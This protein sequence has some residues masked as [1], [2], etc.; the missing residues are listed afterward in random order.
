MNK[1]LSRWFVA[2]SFVF[3]FFLCFSPSTNT[4]NVSLN[5]V[6][7]RSCSF[8]HEGEVKREVLPEDCKKEAVGLG[9]VPDEKS[10]YV[11]YRIR[12]T[13]NDENIAY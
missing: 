3:A 4:K 6:D 9:V 8:A 1:K 12:S 10:F 13:E 11:D 5:S 2:M 7:E